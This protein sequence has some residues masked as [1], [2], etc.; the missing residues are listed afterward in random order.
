MAGRS[1]LEEKFARAILERIEKDRLPPGSR[2]PPERELAAQLDTSRYLV[3][4]ALR[5]LEARGILDR[6]PQSGYYIQR[7]PGEPLP[8]GVKDGARLVSV[9]LLEPAQQPGV[10]R[11]QQTLMRR[12][13]M[14]HTYFAIEHGSSP[15]EERDYLLHAADS[16]ASAILIHATPVAPTN[17]ELFRELSRRLCLVHIGV[18][19]LELPEQAF[20]APDYRLAGA[21]AAARLLACGCRRVHFVSS[22]PAEHH[23]TRLIGA[24]A[25]MAAGTERVRETAPV[26]PGGALSPASERPLRRLTR[27]DGLVLYGSGAAAVV[28]G[29]L[30]RQRLPPSRQPRLVRITDNAEEAIP[31]PADVL[32]FSWLTRVEDAVEYA[33]RGRGPCYRLYPPEWVRPT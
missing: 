30:T 1:F 11:L 33:L 13:V 8:I 2:L 25:A 19:G 16:G 5:L 3:R 14:L 7:I 20:F 6:R 28:A 15:G 31:R 17:E 32:A 10:G 24:G 22:L 9:M 18:H 21:M 23:V 26:F 29:H 27:Q 4:A 12:G